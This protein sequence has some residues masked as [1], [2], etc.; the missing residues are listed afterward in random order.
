MR[1]GLASQGSLDSFGNQL[2]MSFGCDQCSSLAFCLDSGFGLARNL[3]ELFQMKP[4]CFGARF[5]GEQSWHVAWSC[6]A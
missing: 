2:D 6:T 5:C 4:P 1:G 3:I